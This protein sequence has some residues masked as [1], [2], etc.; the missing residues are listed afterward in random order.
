M[1][2]IYGGIM[3]HITAWQYKLNA[4]VSAQL[5][6]MDEG[7]LW[8]VAAIL[9]IAFAYGMIHAVGPGHGKALVGFYFLKAGGS[10]ARAFRM[11]YLIAVIHALSALTVTLVLFYILQTLF[12]KTFLEVSQF[13]MQLSGALIVAVGFYLVYEAYRHRRDRDE[14]SSPGAKSDLA[15]ALSAGIVPCP[16]VMT[17]TLFALSLGH[18]AVGIATAL[19]MSIGMGLTISLAGIVSVGVQKRGGTFL[20]KHGYWLQFAAAGLVILLGIFLFLGA[21]GRQ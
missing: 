9:G 17:I 13:S 1:T 5:R 20:G 11:G 16:G 15:V 8:G 18:V 4:L 12:S 6:G 19:V 21:Q 10:Y 3:H 2:E 14:A 7:S